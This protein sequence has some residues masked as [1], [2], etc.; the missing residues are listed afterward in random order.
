MPYEKFKCE[1]CGFIYN[2]SKLT[3]RDTM[4]GEYC[5]ECGSREKCAACGE[6]YAKA[7]ITFM[8][9]VKNYICDDCI[10]DY[11]SVADYIKP[12]PFVLLW[13]RSASGRGGAGGGGC[14]A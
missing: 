9:E 13:R 11:K 2:Q 5:P 1:S 4:A 6:E 7:Q 10:H 8:D 12:L 14:L 3:R